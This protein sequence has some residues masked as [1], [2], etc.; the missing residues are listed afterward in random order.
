MT[1]AKIPRC[2]LNSITHMMHAPNG[3]K[4]EKHRHE[5]SQARRIRFSQLLWQ[6]LLVEKEDDAIENPVMH[7]EHHSKYE[8][9]SVSKSWY[10]HM[11]LWPKLRYYFISA[12]KTQCKYVKQIVT[13]AADFRNKAHFI[14]F[15]AKTIPARPKFAPLLS[16]DSFFFPLACKNNHCTECT[17]S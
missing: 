13:F 8:P 9:T 4:E 14:R 10:C 12:P 1:L 6:K 5:N 17:V 7:L 11:K 15:T 16:P 2:I 3:H